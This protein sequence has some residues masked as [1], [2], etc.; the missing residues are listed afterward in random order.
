MLPNLWLFSWWWFCL[1]Q[2]N[3]ASFVPRGIFR[4]SCGQ[5]H[6]HLNCFSVNCLFITSI[7]RHLPRHCFFP[8]AVMSIADILFK[9]LSLNNRR[10]VIF[11]PVQL[12]LKL[13]LCLLTNGYLSKQKCRGY[14][15][16]MPN[17]FLIGSAK[18]FSTRLVRCLLTTTLP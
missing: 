3:N 15:V 5:L 4:K 10:N 17:A 13:C 2:H 14:I 12:P 18:Y 9:L 7:I 1:L 11:A 16:K 8:S 6:W